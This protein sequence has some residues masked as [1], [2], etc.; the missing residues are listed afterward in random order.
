MHF[1]NFL[2]EM[3]DTSRRYK[4]AAIISNLHYYTH[5]LSPPISLICILGTISSTLNFNA[6][7]SDV[8]QEKLLCSNTIMVIQQ[9]EYSVN[10]III[11]CQ[12]TDVLSPAQRTSTRPKRVNVADV[13]LFYF[14]CKNAP[15]MIAVNIETLHSTFGSFETKRRVNVCFY[16]FSSQFQFA[17][18][19]SCWYGAVLEE[20][21]YGVLHCFL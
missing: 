14:L 12:K 9:H 16:L 6:Q 15:A 20:K 19:L 3:L 11:F 7:S 21:N 17:Q 13:H 10:T 8:T 18:S 4:T 5:F 2:I 1:L